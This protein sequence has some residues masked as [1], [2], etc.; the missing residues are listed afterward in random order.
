MVSRSERSGPAGILH[1]EGC[2][3]IPMTLGLLSL[4]DEITPEVWWQDELHLCTSTILSQRSH[5]EEHSE[6]P[7][8]LMV[9]K[10]FQFFRSSGSDLVRKHARNSDEIM[11]GSPDEFLCC[12]HDSFPSFLKRLDSEMFSRLVTQ[13]GVHVGVRLRFGDKSKTAPSSLAWASDPP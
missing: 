11:L 5:N 4:S 13:S 8:P 2:S 1:S 10:S 3:K 6:R 12:P 9:W 7:E